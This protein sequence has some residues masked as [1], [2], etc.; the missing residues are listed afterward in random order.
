MTAE[1]TI[2][3]PCATCGGTGIDKTRLPDIDRVKRDTGTR[4]EFR[5]YR[6]PACTDGTIRQ[7]REGA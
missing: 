2:R 4:H 3:V 6:C 7:A 1:L 5:S